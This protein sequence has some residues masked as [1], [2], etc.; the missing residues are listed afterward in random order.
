MLKQLCFHATV[1]VLTFL[2]VTFIAAPTM[3]AQSFELRREQET[4]FFKG[5]INRESANALIE[6]IRSGASLIVIT[7]EGG[8]AKD[9]LDVAKEMASNKVALQVQDYCF[10]SCANYLFVAAL[11]KKLMPDAV[12]GFHGGVSGAAKNK[13]ELNHIKN[14]SFQSEL[15]DLEREEQSFYSSLGFDSTLIHISAL[16]TIA[17]VPAIFKVELD[18]DKHVYTFSNRAE[19]AVFL[20]KTIDSMTKYRISV[21]RPSPRVYFPNQHM[22][23]K[24]G[25]KGITDY[26]YPVNQQAMDMLA[27]EL[28]VELIGDYVSDQ[29]LPD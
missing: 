1:T 21:A 25:V 5:E 9:A 4:V 16:L 24:Y 26:P 27:K 11:Q 12:L 23:T 14:T 6:Q 29:K 18:D 20:S 8:S 13:N 10:S 17:T 15:N 7:S 3:A 28:E 2:I 22:L 19:L